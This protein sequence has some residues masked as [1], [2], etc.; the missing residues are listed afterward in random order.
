MKRFRRM[1]RFSAFLKKVNLWGTNNLNQIDWTKQNEST[2]KIIKGSQV[3]INHIKA[4]KEV[5][6]LV[7][8]C[9][10]IVSACFGKHRL[11]TAEMQLEKVGTFSALKQ[12]KTSY[13]ETQIGNDRNCVSHQAR[14]ERTFVRACLSRF[15][16]SVV[17]NRVFLHFCDPLGE[18]MLEVNHLRLFLRF[19][20]VSLL[21]R[22]DVTTF[23]K[24]TFSGTCRNTQQNWN[25]DVGYTF[26]VLHCFRL[27]FDEIPNEGESFADGLVPEKALRGSGQ[28]CHALNM[29]NTRLL[30]SD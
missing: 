11:P 28:T 19:S 24:T 14:L 30:Y 2:Q 23:I 18:M 20:W 3:Q 10:E 17:K 27:L 5:D 4:I 26:A 9:C 1:T 15:C 21:Q 16:G 22:G 25:R 12:G 29:F 13:S 6:V 7:F 8:F